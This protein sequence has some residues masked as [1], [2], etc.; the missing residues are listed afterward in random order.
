MLD[1]HGYVSEASGENL[2]VI[3][4]CVVATAPLGASILGG[5][6]RDSVLTFLRRAGIP[7]VERLIGRDELYLADEV[8]L[9][10]TAAE[11]TPVREVD[12]RPVGN[13][14]RG[15]ITEQVQSSYF[16]AVRGSDV[17]VPTWLTIV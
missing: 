4:Y 14:R 12:D 9:V 8:F 10:G 16:R 6:T 15:P 1:P 11:V 13:G 17:P 3:R 7:R 2:L 5:I